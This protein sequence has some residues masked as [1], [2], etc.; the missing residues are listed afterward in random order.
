[1][2]GS[3]A[4]ST[5]VM[6]RPLLFVSLL[7][8]LGNDFIDESKI[9]VLPRRTFR[10]CIESDGLPLCHQPDAFFS[11]D[12][13][14]RFADHL[15]SVLGCIAIHLEMLDDHLDGILGIVSCMNHS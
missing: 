11:R 12:G 10:F 8:K 13:I 5:M 1:M 2:N 15:I 6:P 4:F 9:H 3:R 7:S 14:K